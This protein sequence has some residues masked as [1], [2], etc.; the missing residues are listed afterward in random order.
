MCEPALSPIPSSFASAF[1]KPASVLRAI[2]TILPSEESEAAD[3]LLHRCHDIPVLGSGLVGTRPI[4]SASRRVR[5]TDI[6][7]SWAPVIAYSAIIE[8]QPMS[9]VT[10][11]A[12]R[13]VQRFEIVLMT[14]LLPFSSAIAIGVADTP[15]SDGRHICSSGKRP[16]HQVGVDDRQVELRGER[17]RRDGVEAAGLGRDRMGDRPPEVLLERLERDDDLV[18]SRKLL[19]HDRRSAHHRSRHDERIVGHLF[20]IDDRDRTVLLDRLPSEQRPDIRIAATAG[21]E[22]GSAERKIVELLRAELTHR[23]TSRAPG[24]RLPSP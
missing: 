21:A 15:E 20:G 6:S 2:S 3:S 11:R 12:I 8:E 9:I 5:G 24:R 1:A 17:E 13:S 19:D 7:F 16:A 18:T 23:R 22:D 14:T 10:D 4:S